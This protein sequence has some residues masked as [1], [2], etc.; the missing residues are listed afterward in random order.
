MHRSTHESTSPPAEAL[1]DF[2]AKQYKIHEDIGTNLSEFRAGRNKLRTFVTPRPSMLFGRLLEGVKTPWNLGQRYYELLNGDF[3][4][5]EYV[6]DT[7][8]SDAEIVQSRFEICA[9]MIPG[10]VKVTGSKVDVLRFPNGDPTMCQRLAVLQLLDPSI[11]LEEVSASIPK[12][13]RADEAQWSTGAAE[14]LAKLLKRAQTEDVTD[15]EIRN[16]PDM[17]GEV[18]GG[19]QAATPRAPSPIRSSDHEPPA[20]RSKVSK[21]KPIPEL[22][23]ASMKEFAGAV[24]P[25]FKALVLSARHEIP[26]CEMGKR[27]GKNITDEEQRRNSSGLTVKL[28]CAM[29]L[30]SSGVRGGS[31]TLLRPQGESDVNSVA[32]KLASMCKLDK[33]KVLKKLESRSANENYQSEDF[34]LWFTTARPI[35]EANNQAGSEAQP[36]EVAAAA[37]AA[38]EPSAVGP[39]AGNSNEGESW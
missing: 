38:A 37:P 32:N 36:S 35:F 26:T 28:L 19:S 6:M 25:V 16:C 18:S 31:I 14:S 24:C 11:E 17:F 21:T 29:G 10:L 7:S 39:V 4:W 20:K 33:A 34:E 23:A 8:I 9:L 12:G 30:G 22:S 13:A 15:D 5:D 1:A 3:N 27:V 2:Y